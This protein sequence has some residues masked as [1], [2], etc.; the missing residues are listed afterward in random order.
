MINVEERARLKMN[1]HAD[2]INATFEL[3]GTALNCLSIY[4]VYKDKC[5]KG[6]SVVPTTF[7]FSWGLW[8]IYFYPTMNLWLSFWAGL[9]IIFSNATWVALA[10]YYRHRNEKPF[11]A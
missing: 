9:A 7:Y 2:A 6:V 4:R 10:L 5:I 8:N 3:V 1:P 11:P